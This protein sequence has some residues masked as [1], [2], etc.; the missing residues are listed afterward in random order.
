MISGVPQGSVLGPLLFLLYSSDLT[1]VLQYSTASIYADDT[2][3]FRAV[4]NVQDCV[5]L[6]SDLNRV[7]MWASDWQ[8]S[9]NEAKTRLLR[10]GKRE[11]KFVYN[12]NGVEVERV[13][14]MKDLGIIIQDDLKFNKQ[15]AAVVRK[16]NF[17]CRGIHVVF[18][19]HSTDF[20]RKLFDTYVRPI[21]YYCSPVWS[22]QSLGQM[23]ELEDV[24]R[25]FSRFIPQLRNMTYSD[26]LACLE[27]HELS[28]ELN[29][30]DLIFVHRVLHGNYEIRHQNSLII[31]Q[32][33]RTRGHPLK[34]TKLPFRT[35]LRRNFVFNRILNDWNKL[36][37]RLVLTPP[38][39]F[40]DNIRHYLLGVGVV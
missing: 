10:I 1:T 36:H 12:I 27:W 38:H 22:Q 35:T 14:S 4:H 19:G 11:K 33:F 39:L 37:E 29:A 31:A 2:K 32:N 8:L 20:Y 28:F 15:I 16:G 21:I 34:L 6:Q 40:A 18:R 17:A 24:V 5:L 26:R 3:L 13:N 30:I 23:V 9:L 7:S 25:R